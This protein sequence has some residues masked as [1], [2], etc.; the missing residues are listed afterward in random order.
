MVPA[1]LVAHKLNI[2]FIR[3]QLNRISVSVASLSIQLLPGDF[4]NPSEGDPEGGHPG[5]TSKVRQQSHTAQAAR[6]ARHKDAVKYTSAMSKKAKSAKAEVRK[7][8]EEVGEKAAPAPA[9]SSKAKGVSNPGTSGGTVIIKAEEEKKQS[10]SPSPVEEQ[11][12]L[13]ESGG[14]QQIYIIQ[15]TDGSMPMETAEVV[16]ADDM[17]VYETVSALEQLSRGNVVTTATTGEGGELIQVWA[18][19]L[20]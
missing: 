14:G 1:F 12:P 8:T 7:E 9:S 15:T 16:V 18:K 11:Q 13:V 4:S 17:A 5:A 3:S 6:S 20:T 2:S 10:A 19:Y